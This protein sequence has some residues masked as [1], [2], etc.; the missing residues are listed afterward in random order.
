MGKGET[1]IL[2]GGLDKIGTGSCGLATALQSGSETQR[3]GGAFAKLC[4]QG[5]EGKGMEI[6]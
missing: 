1:T 5:C 4:R 2:N 6:Y 3:V